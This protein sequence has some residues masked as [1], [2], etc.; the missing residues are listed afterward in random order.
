MHIDKNLKRINVGAAITHNG[1]VYNGNVMQF[2]AVVEEL[3]IQEIA[4]PVIPADIEAEY[5]A[6]PEWYYVNDIDDAP[7]RVW[8]KKS[9]DQ[10]AAMTMQAAKLHRVGVVERIT[11][12]TAAGNTFDG[13]ERSQDRMA[14]SLAVMDDGESLPWVLADNT[15]ATV[16]KVELREALRLAGAAMAAEWVKPYI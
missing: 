7:Y 1:V 6:H 14:R 11:V 12:T 16:T 10:I 3:G 2:P 5:M 4:D 15:L 8:T 9:D 13:G